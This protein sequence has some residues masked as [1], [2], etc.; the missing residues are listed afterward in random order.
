[1]AKMKLLIVLLSLVVLGCLGQNLISLLQNP[2]VT[3]ESSSTFPTGDFRSVIKAE[4]LRKIREG[5]LSSAAVQ[6]NNAD[7]P[8]QLYAGFRSIEAQDPVDNRTIFRLAS[9]SKGVTAVTMLQYT[10]KKL[11]NLDD[12]VSKY[13]PAFLNTTVL[14][15]VTPNSHRFTSLSANHGSALVII[16][17]PSLSVSSIA[18]LNRKQVGIQLSGSTAGLNVDGI[19]T[20]TSFNPSERTVTI[21][22]TDA[23]NISIFFTANGTLDV[24]P[25]LLPHRSKYEYVNAPSNASNPTQYSRVYYTTEPSTPVLIHHL[26]ANT[27][28]FAYAS[29]GYTKDLTSLQTAIMLKK[30]PLLARMPLT[31]TINVHNVEYAA[32]IAV[33]PMLGEP[34]TQ[35]TYGPQTSI[36]AAVIVAYEGR[37]NPNISLY[38]IQKRNLFDPLDITDAGYFIHDNDL[39][40]DEKIA[41]LAHIYTNLDS[42]ILGSANIVPPLY[43]RVVN[44]Q[45]Y[46][47]PGLQAAL[48]DGA[49]P[50]GEGAA[51]PT[52]PI[53]GSLA[54]RK[55]EAGDAGLYMR[56][57]EFQRIV[58]MLANNGSYNGK[59]ILQPATVAQMFSNQIGSLTVT[60]EAIPDGNAKWGYGVAVG[61]ESSNFN[62][63]V[64]TTAHWGGSF[65][66]W[67]FANQYPTLSAF[68]FASNVLPGSF[69]TTTVDVA[70]ALSQ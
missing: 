63:L 65:G 12:P 60:H 33:I 9:I 42:R 22:L 45:D 40:R 58:T 39:R 35:W 37:T 29:P 24:L 34:G 18:H 8:Y 27:A 26:L 56:L 44:L 68:A 59:Q 17:L 51:N 4:A 70:Y 67:F 5:S 32:R 66:G 53:Y 6:L 36:A 47:L 21:T 48:M 3:F 10:E 57:D 55:Y 64:Q 16:A 52:H 49:N 61:D 7:Y 62:A 30:D 2:P 19:F 46:L 50:S 54:P 41:N 13:I 23:V 20:I 25:D 15:K 28:G 11:I 14:H 31:P 43:S 38:E 69:Q 1:M